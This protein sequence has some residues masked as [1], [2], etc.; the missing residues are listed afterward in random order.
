MGLLPQLGKCLLLSFVGLCNPFKPILGFSY[1]LPTYGNLVLK[2]LLGT[3]RVS[4]PIIR[5]YARG[6]PHA[7]TNQ[8]LINLIPLKHPQS[9]DHFP[10]KPLRPLL[11]IVVHTWSYINFPFRSFLSMTSA[12]FDIGDFKTVSVSSDF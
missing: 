6:R 9:L 10:T 7:L 4:L 3:S 12:Q 11:Q 2:I 8:W 5:P 1:L